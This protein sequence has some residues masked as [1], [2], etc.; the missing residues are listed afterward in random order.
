MRCF[1]THVWQNYFNNYLRITNLTPDHRN[2][3]KTITRAPTTRS[4]QNIFGIRVS[5]LLVHFLK[6][7]HHFFGFYYAELF[8]ID[9]DHCIKFFFD[10]A[11]KSVG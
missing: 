4:D 10:F 7:D 2:T 1:D 3:Q 9:I 8:R 5:H 6:L 11:A